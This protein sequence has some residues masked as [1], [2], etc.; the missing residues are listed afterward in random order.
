MIE[1]RKF[2]ISIHGI[3]VVGDVRKIKYNK[4]VGC[5]LLP[6]YSIVVVELLPVKAEDI[7]RYVQFYLNICL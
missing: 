1:L 6:L 2:A 5:I 4:G 3:K 7:I